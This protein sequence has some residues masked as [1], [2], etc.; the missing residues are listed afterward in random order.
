MENIW[1]EVPILCLKLILV[2]C[3]LSKF[4]QRA[5]EHVEAKHCNTGGYECMLCQ[6][7]CPTASSLR[8]HNDRHHKIKMWSKAWNITLLFL[9]DDVLNA[10]IEQKMGK[11]ED[12]WQCLDCLWT[13][14][15]RTRLW[16]HIEAEHVQSPGYTC[17]LCFV[18]LK[19]GWLTTKP[20]IT[21]DFSF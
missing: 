11:L 18:L 7:Y 4:K 20:E 2:G 14:K 16:E 1:G 6:K 13:T 9:S 21:L 5:W 10:S 15:N 8:N 17:Q 19:G 3:V 12:L